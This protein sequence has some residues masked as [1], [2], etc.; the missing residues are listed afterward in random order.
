MVR[1]RLGKSGLFVS[2]IGY[3]AFKLGR[4]EKIKYAQPYPLPNDG[5]VARL[6]DELCALGINY[7]D[8][9]PAY[10]SSEERLGRVLGGRADVIISTKVGEDFA[11][12]VSSF[13]FSAP[14]IRASIE[15]SLRRLQRD[16]LDLVF[17]HAPAEDL[18]V[19]YATDAV[20]T[21]LELRAAG[22]IRA[23][24]FSGKTVTAAEAALGWAD[25]LMVEYHLEDRSHAAVLAA[26]RT[27]D[28]GIVVKKGLASGRLD[29]RVAIPAVLRH[30]A[31]G[32][33]VVGGL[34]IAHMRANVEYAATPSGAADATEPGERR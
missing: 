5:E 2:P 17:I 23:L 9:A 20:A 22:H 10:G 1:R 4:N 8:T 27:A 6:L 32:S 21:L 19:L 12:G 34:S 7:F 14:G 11:D 25:V 30:P 28:V 24:G 13:D 33:L 18:H 31:I 15:R 29:P 16:V 3:G 26:A